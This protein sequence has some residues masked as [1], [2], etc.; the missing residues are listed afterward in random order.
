MEQLIKA[1]IGI[2]RFTENRAESIR[3]HLINRLE[4]K[5]EQA[6]V[7]REK[8]KVANHVDTV[9]EIERHER[10]LERLAQVADKIDQDCDDCVDEIE[11]KIRKASLA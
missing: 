9:C 4:T 8:A 7:A 5:Q 3:T 11:D 6:K 1:L 10:A 2:A